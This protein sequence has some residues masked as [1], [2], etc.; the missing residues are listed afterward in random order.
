MKQSIFIVITSVFL[1]LVAADIDC[2]QEKDKMCATLDVIK[3]AFDA[4]YAPAYWKKTFVGWE[5]ETK[6][7]EAKARVRRSHKITLKD[8]QH[9]I[10]DFF[11]STRDYHVGVHFFSTEVARLPFSVKGAGGKYFITH[12]D[13]ERLNPAVYPF[14]VGD[15]LIS[16]NG[17]PTAIAVQELKDQEVGNASAETDLAMAAI[18][19]TIRTGVMGHKVP[20]GPVT[21]AV[22]SSRTGA[23]SSYQLIWLYRPEKVTSCPSRRGFNSAGDVFSGSAAEALEAIFNKKLEAPFIIPVMRLMDSFDDNNK[24]VVGSR[25]GFLPAL[26]RKVWSAP[27][28]S[29]FH[30]YLYQTPDRSL[31]GYI[32][33][34]HYRGGSKEVEAFG[35]I[36]S[37]LEENS[38]AL[39]IDQMNNPGGSAFYLYALASMLT[40][41]PLEAP[42]HHIAIT[43]REVM[44]AVSMMPYFEMVRSN[45]DAQELIGPTLAGN[46]VTYQMAQ[47][48]L[49]YFRFIVDE[50]KAGRRLTNLFYLY[51]VDHIN[52]HPTTRYTKP[53]L[54]LVNSLDFSGGDVFP[55]ILQDNKRATLFG[56]RTAG[57]GGFVMQATFPNHFGIDSYHFTASLAE[58]AQGAP[59]ENLGVEPDIPYT[60]TQDDLK[61]G[62]HPMANAINSCVMELLE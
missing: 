60:V 39:I 14:E 38:D 8:F 20:K 46:P 59:I 7:E 3:S 12:I 15:E 51:G 17:K 11:K 26:G 45:S 47:F 43:Q 41:A 54:L 10:S 62:Y 52:P 22:R 6:I 56:S 37:Y 42:R 24:E 49:N 16:F 29:P 53:I 48:F 23:T 57:A 25:E 40:E 1:P 13:R 2:S 34:P 33:I 9:I 35:D 32:R 4:Q 27:S 61:C 55:I 19:L 31:V 50:W 21:I 44:E 58:R 18:Y 28:E 36:I 30:A 5:L